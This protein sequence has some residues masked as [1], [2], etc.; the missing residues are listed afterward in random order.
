MFRLQSF[1][2]PEEEQA[3]GQQLCF[4]RPHFRFLEGIAHR[5]IFVA[6][7]LQLAAA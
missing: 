3:M 2:G 1:Q 5:Y 7:E 6:W 4:D